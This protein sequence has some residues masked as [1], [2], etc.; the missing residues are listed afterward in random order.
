[1][2]G[3]SGDDVW[4]CIF[5]SLQPYRDDLLKYGFRWCSTNGSGAGHR[6]ATLS[7]TDQNINASDPVGMLDPEAFYPDGGTLQ[8]IFAQK[9]AYVVSLLPHPPETIFPPL[10]HETPSLEVAFETVKHVPGGKASSRTFPPSHTTAA[11][12]QCDFCGAIMPAKFLSNHSCDAKPRV[13]VEGGG[14]KVEG[15]S[16]SKATNEIIEISSDEHSDAE[17]DAEGAEG[18]GP[19]N[20]KIAAV[21]AKAKKDKKR[22]L[23][24]TSDSAGKERHAAPSATSKKGCG[25]TQPQDKVKFDPKNDSKK[26][27]C[28]VCNKKETPEPW[29]EDETGQG[30]GKLKSPV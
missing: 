9:Q 7:L 17:P 10:P 26:Q 15:A 14:V 21:E 20:R 22:K 6:L 2:P 11:G 24:G 1:M 23:S 27:I 13:K 5:T 3:S 4:E 25:S 29:S 28:P 12:S 18:A 30:N 19:L 16:S 8:A